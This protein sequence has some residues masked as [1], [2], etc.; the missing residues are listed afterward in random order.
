MVFL[1]EL[2]KTLLQLS[3]NENEGSYLKVDKSFRWDEDKIH[4]QN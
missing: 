2:H 1:M 3:K 4:T